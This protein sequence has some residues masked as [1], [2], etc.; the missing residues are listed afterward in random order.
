[1]LLELGVKRLEEAR[2]VLVLDAERL[3]PNKEVHVI[4]RLANGHLRE[5]LKGRLGGSMYLLAMAE[6]IRLATEDAL[7]KHLPEEDEVGFGYLMPGQK[8][9]QYG[10]KRLFDGDFRGS[11]EFLR[12]FNLDYTVKLR[13]YVEGDTEAGA[14]EALFGDFE[15]FEC[16]NLSGQV[17]A[18]G[19]RGLAFK[20]DLTRDLRA[21]VFSFVAIDGDRKE[22]VRLLRMAAEDDIFCGEF[23]ISDPDFEFWNFN[24]GELTDVAWQMA[25]EQNVG[26]E[27]R[28]RFSTACARSSSAKDFTRRA[29]AAIPDFRLDIAKGKRWGKLLMAYAA[30][31]P[32]RIDPKSGKSALRPIL[33]LAQDAFN[34]VDAS[35]HFH[36]MTMRVDP[37]SGRLVAR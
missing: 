9:K 7:G 17:S 4:L 31:N 35:F 8:E 20:E 30:K 3:D 32:N 10:S 13:W 11:K 14:L 22:F 33:Q 15:P 6:M 5:H 16:V 2:R 36:R 24:V 12:S 28:E 25:L 37:Q 19:G 29:S 21:G 18:S 34:A 23:D 1:M 26:E 27:W